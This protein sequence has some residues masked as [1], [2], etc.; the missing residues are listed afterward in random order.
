MAEIELIGVPFDGYGRRGN[1]ALAAGALRRAGLAAALG[2]PEHDA[3]LPLPGPV[4]E[5]GPAG[6]LLN[7]PALISATDQ[8]AVR[9]AAAV[10]GGRFPVVHGG[11]CATLLGTVGGLRTATGAAGLVFVDGHEDAIPLDV[12]EDGEAANTEIG[13]LLGLTGRLLTGPL[14]RRR[15]VL[16]RSALAV[17]GT[18]DREWRAGF[19][20]GSLR[21]AGVWLREAEEVATAPRAAGRAAAEHVVA[22][23]ARWWLHVDLDVLD[24]DVFPAQGLP[25]VPDEPGGLSWAALTDLLLGALEVPGCAGWSVAIYDPEQDPTGDCA[26]DVVRLAERVAAVLG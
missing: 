5:R 1:Q 12:S 19:A 22:A 20:V 25:G 24:P 3:V 21:D 7:E 10:A 13:L 9:V 11:D 6:G 18:R 26:A 8:L 17:L 16:D 14:A 15:G 4:A 2:S 23:S